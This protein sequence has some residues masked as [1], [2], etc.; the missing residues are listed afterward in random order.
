MLLLASFFWGSTFIV[1]SDAAGKLPPL[2]YLAARSY[3]GAAAIALVV[4]ARGL[5]RRRRAKTD[6]VFA[7][8]RASREKLPVKTVLLGGACCGAA[9]L[10]AGYLQQQGIT[11]GAT[12]GEAGFLTALVWRCLKSRMWWQQAVRSVMLKATSVFSSCRQLLLRMTIRSINL[13]WRLMLQ[14]YLMRPVHAPIHL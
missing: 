13:M 8:E 12:A 14:M 10:V 2:T 1:Q 4:L 9:L 6:R 11:F 7:D 3:V 5:Y